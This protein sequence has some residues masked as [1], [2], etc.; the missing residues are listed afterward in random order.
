MC[1]YKYV[2]V[3]AYVF[4]H[5]CLYV[6][7]CMCVCLCHNTDVEVK[8]QLAEV[9]SQLLPYGF[10]EPSPGG[11]AQGR[12]PSPPSHPAIPHLHFRMIFLG[13]ES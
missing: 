2:C 1:T 8:R 4:M 5:M 7:V 10:R 6:Y 3:H 11:P 12:A 9:S 13:T